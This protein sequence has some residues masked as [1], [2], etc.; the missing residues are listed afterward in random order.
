MNPAGFHWSIN[1]YL[2]DYTM[3]VGDL[4]FLLRFLNT[5]VVYRDGV[6]ILSEVVDL[7]SD[8]MTT[9]ISGILR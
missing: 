1:P 7:K 5:A 9:L 8:Y 4:T 2:S 6:M 3:K